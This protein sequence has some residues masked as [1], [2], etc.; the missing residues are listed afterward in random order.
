M[1]MTSDAVVEANANTKVR[2]SKTSTS[3]RAITNS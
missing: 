1:Q 2:I 3:S